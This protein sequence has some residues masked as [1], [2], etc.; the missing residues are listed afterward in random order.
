MVM[1]WINCLV[2]DWIK[3]RA[4]YITHRGW[5]HGMYCLQ[6]EFCD[7]TFERGISSVTSAFCLNSDDTFRECH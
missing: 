6:Y 5:G 7:K 3:Y 4:C 2:T 1:V